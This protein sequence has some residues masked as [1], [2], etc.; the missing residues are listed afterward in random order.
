MDYTNAGKWAHPTDT[1]EPEGRIALGAYLN[2]L[3]SGEEV[4]ALAVC[5]GETARNFG[6]SLPSSFDPLLWNVS[7][8]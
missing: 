7:T 5:W 8:G 6:D 2:R 3:F 4:E 1:R